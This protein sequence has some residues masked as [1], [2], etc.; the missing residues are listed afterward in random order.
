M[1]KIQ[2]AAVE[3]AAKV[4]WD[5]EMNAPWS[6]V[7]DGFK[8][9]FLRDARQVIEAAAPFM[10]PLS[11]RQSSRAVGALIN[12]AKANGW[13]EGEAA[14]Q[15]NAAAYQVGHATKSNPYRPAP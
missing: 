8:A 6:S 10:P 4:L 7:S 2:E 13:D 12:A 14:G 15:D 9:P 5:K 11:R 1:S 3:A